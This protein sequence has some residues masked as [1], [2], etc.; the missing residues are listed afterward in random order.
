MGGGT[1]AVVSV[2]RLSSETESFVHRFISLREC[3][4]ETKS[5]FA[6][7]N[8]PFI[9]APSRDSLIEAC[10]DSDLV[11]LN[12]WNSPEMGEFLH[13]CLPPMR[14][15]AWCHVGGYAIPQM[16]PETL[17]GFV[18]YAAA[19]SAYT[20]DSPA[21]RSLPTESRL[22]KTGL[23]FAATDPSRVEHIQR[24]PHDAFNVG[25]VG[26]VDYVKMHREFVSM[27]ANIQ[28]P[29]IRFIICGQ[30]RAESHI[31][32]E[33]AR[34]GLQERFDLRGHVDD[35]RA[36]FEIL[37]VYGYPLCEDTYAGSELNLQEAML[38][39]IPAVVFPHGGL[40]GLVLD[41]L[42][43]YVV[44]SAASYRE[45]IEHLYRHPQE[46]LRLG[47]NARSY[48]RAMFDPDRT[49]RQFCRV[50]RELLRSPKRERRWP[51]TLTGVCGGVPSRYRGAEMF[52]ESLENRDGRFAGSYT[53]SDLRSVLEAENS[54]RYCSPLLFNALERYVSFYP[55]DPY[56]LL[57]S[58][59]AAWGAGEQL[60][61]LTSIAAAATHGLSHWRA[62]WYMAQLGREMDDAMLC[63]TALE[64]VLAAAQDFGPALDLHAS[65]EGKG[66][67]DPSPIALPTPDRQ[68]SGTPPAPIGGHFRA[69]GRL[70]K[71]TLVT[72]SF[73][74]AKYLEACI[75]SVLSQDYPALEYIIMD[76]G[77]TDGSL[78]IIK[79]YSRYLTYWQSMPDG[80]H[81]PAIQ[82]GFTKGT[83]EVMGW[84]NSDDM[85]YA[86][87]LRVV[88]AVF[89]DRP[90]VEVLTGKAYAYDANGNIKQALFPLQSWCRYFLLSMENWK[91]TVRC[92]AQ[93]ATYWRRSIW[94]RS[95]RGLDLSLK[96]A[97]D[98]ELWCRFSREA[99]I[100]NVDARIGAMRNWGDEQ[101][102]RRFMKEYKGECAL[103]IEREQA[104]GV[105]AR[106]FHT[107]P[108]PLIGNPFDE[109]KRR[110][111]SSPRTVR[112][113]PP[114][115]ARTQR[116]DY[117]KISI[118]TVCDGDGEYLEECFDSVLSQEWPH[119]EY[120]VV[121]PGV[122]SRIASIVKRYGSYMQLLPNAERAQGYKA[123]NVALKRA[124][125]TVVGWLRPEDKMHAGA[126]STL[127][128]LFHMR[129]DIQWIVGRPNVWR[130]DG[131]LLSV[132][133]VPV[134]YARKYWL[135]GSYCEPFI[136][137]ES[138]FWRRDLWLQAGGYLDA[139]YQYA[140]DF[141]L[142][143]RFSRYAPI[144]SVNFL[145]AG[146]RENAEGRYA[147]LAQLYHWE[148]E[149]IAAREGA[150]RTEF[151]QSQPPPPVLSL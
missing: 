3:S 134:M 64:R 132:A 150:V 100:H 139:S 126:L 93:E 82:A 29:N 58:G 111:Q 97:A 147:R 18:D 138:I 101:R 116:S 127:G 73:N 103:V 20:Y 68:A 125:G 9:A 69:T 146:C 143:L 71:L 63:R 87:G 7:H 1:R 53:A 88:G 39:G 65:L 57:W 34:R 109:P 62:F 5:F 129:P 113:T 123:L 30:G 44:D 89:R 108:P 8:L 55:T 41:N 114:S 105:A 11:Q 19:C 128:N 40:R 26:T 6:S 50:Y 74:Q 90:N 10:R 49:A 16:I 124:T 148:V 84:L 79:K 85:L 32:A 117:P 27:S 4:T 52:L 28:I 81:Y 149:Q 120:I 141:E 36:V 76:G 130:E 51:D 115:F 43:G 38:A 78:D 144:Y 67:L 12:W 92:I 91:H 54:L 22:R 35:I 66:I 121:D 23:F 59:L 60:Q 2:A 140:A 46:R 70:P 119:L 102:S 110:T 106:P 13:S 77:S 17:I 83:G 33:A 56:L 131:E 95:G 96:Y 86:N 136:Y 118:V 47:E 98:F 21:F 112:T 94:E 99:E 80:G 15:L 42:T 14:L 37:D 75:E 137:Q 151:D 45:A 122:S 48:A 135:M 31:R 24:R 145:L 61:A 133:V 104:L 107:Q 72:P 25:Y 142:W